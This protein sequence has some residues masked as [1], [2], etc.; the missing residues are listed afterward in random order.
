VPRLI[1]DPVTRVGGHL[2]IEAE[3]FDGYVAEAWA[4]GTMF[5]GMELVLRGRDA[6]DAWMLAQR[7]CGTCTGV[8]ALASVRAVEQ[9]LGLAIPP[10]ARLI[11]NILAGTQLV[12]DHV[13][14]FYQAQLLDWVDV[15]SATAADPAATAALARAQSAWGKNDAS[16]FARIRDTVKAVVAS[17]QPGVLGGGYWGHPAYQLEPEANLLLVAHLLEA[18]DW[19]RQLMRIHAL[20][21]GKDP[22]PQTYLV[23]GMALA[24]TWRGPS[25][26]LGRDHPRLPERDAPMP[27][28]EHGLEEIARLLDDARPFVDQ[29][30]L[31]DVRLLAKTYPEWWSIGAGRGNYLAFGDY[32]LDDGRNPDRL[33]PGG[34]ILRGDAETL[35]DVDQGSIGETTA[36]AWYGESP[37]DAAPSSPAEGETKPAWSG[38][39]LPVDRLDGTGRYSWVKAPRY[40]GEP[41]ETG[42]LARMLVADAARSREIRTSLGR[43][44]DLLDVTR[45]ALPSAL[46]RL[47]AKAVEASLVMEQT[48]GW[49]DQL[50]SSLGS[51]DIAF[52]DIS[53]W[54]RASWPGELEGWS[55]GEGPRGGVG[56]WVG[57]RDGLIDRYQVVDGSTWN[58]SPRDASDAR[59]PIEAA[60]LG[61][62]VADPAAPLEVLRVVHAFDPC[63]SCAV[64]VHAPGAGGPLQVRVRDRETER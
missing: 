22:H 37:G 38:P 50:R 30:F 53:M 47:V 62:Q 39:P 48:V 14:R 60:L 61:T 54:D 33:L 13:L 41:M 44:L 9:A 2:R 10:N 5:R 18:L 63:A 32:P 25:A 64:H 12:R 45:D 19:Q 46:G 43:M 31:P 51:G 17:D 6:R 11:R 4:S 15:E 16:Y 40:D 59:G 35:A 34:R 49:H 3:V 27:M 20:V 26:R 58:V 21:G 36:R 52:T 23:G 42:P 56:H 28:S 8:H 1:V 29:V 55:L 24:P 57:I 7:I